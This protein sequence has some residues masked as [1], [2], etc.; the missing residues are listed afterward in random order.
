MAT[1]LP[2]LVGL[3]EGSAG[4]VGCSLMQSCLQLI[5]TPVLASCSAPQSSHP[6]HSLLF[7]A[8]PLEFPSL[9]SLCFLGEFSQFL[10]S[11]YIFILLLF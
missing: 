1:V 6:S 7:E 2:R 4:A 3:P 11:Q 9:Y 10:P 8:Y 5:F